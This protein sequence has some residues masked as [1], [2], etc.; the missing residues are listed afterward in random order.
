M[1]KMHREHTEFT[2]YVCEKSGMLGS[3]KESS[4][5]LSLE[6]EEREKAES[7]EVEKTFW[8]FQIA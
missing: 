8:Y 3:P 1:Y 2:K 6:K 4:G 5:R 7:K